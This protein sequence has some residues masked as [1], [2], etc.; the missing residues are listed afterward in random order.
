MTELG[1]RRAH[2]QPQAGRR[3]EDAWGQDM[4]GD[5]R[6]SLVGSELL[7]LPLLPD[8]GH[9]TSPPRAR[10]V[11]ACGVTPLSSPVGQR[12]PKLR[13]TS[14]VPTV[15]VPKHCPGQPWRRGP[16]APSVLPSPRVPSVATP[17][18]GSNVASPC[19]DRCGLAARNLPLF[20]ALVAPEAA[21]QPPPQRGDTRRLTPG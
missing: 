5:S 11:I 17:R 14:A 2:P 7:P 6:G 3:A 1:P 20:P 13:F 8:L 9:G 12:W 18:S 19:R 15:A 16:P 10:D 4:G 21:G